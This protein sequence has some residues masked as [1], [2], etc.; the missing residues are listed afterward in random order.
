[1]TERTDDKNG[2]N[3]NPNQFSGPQAAF[4]D[5]F[6]ATGADYRYEGV[7]RQ[8]FMAGVVWSIGRQRERRGRRS[9]KQQCAM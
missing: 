3:V 1:M 4:L 9:L 8:A 6:K 2:E 5:Y 7:L